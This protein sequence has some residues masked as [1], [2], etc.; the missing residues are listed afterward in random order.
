[1]LFWLDCSLA[2]SRGLPLDGSWSFL[3]AL[4]RYMSTS[5]SY[6]WLISLKMIQKSYSRLFLRPSR[7]KDSLLR[8]LSR[9]FGS[10][11]SDVL[12]AWP[13]PHWWRHVAII[14]KLSSSLRWKWQNIARGSNLSCKENK[15]KKSSR[16]LRLKKEKVSLD[17]TS[18]RGA[19][20]SNLFS[21]REKILWQQRPLPLSSLS[22]LEGG[23]VSNQARANR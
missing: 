19:R 6:F 8:Y 9:D 16:W 18:Q 12:A 20:R 13:S 14:Y 17:Q 3:L 22:W 7:W 5:R 21:Q 15:Q 2:L 4:S 10:W 1:M 23:K 11:H